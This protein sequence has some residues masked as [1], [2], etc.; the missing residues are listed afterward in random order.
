[1]HVAR[2]LAPESFQR[3]FSEMCFSFTRVFPV[4]KLIFFTDY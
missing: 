1:M 3:L 4:D 2:V